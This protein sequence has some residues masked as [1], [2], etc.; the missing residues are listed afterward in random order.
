MGRRVLGRRVP[1]WAREMMKGR[2]A[3]QAR[4]QGKDGGM[5]APEHRCARKDRERQTKDKSPVMPVVA[6][7]DSP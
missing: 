2:G 4:K 7:R 3:K 1:S 6:G 5:S